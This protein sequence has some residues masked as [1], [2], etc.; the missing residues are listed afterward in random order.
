MAAQR[1]R[2][3]TTVWLVSNSH[4]Q[5]AAGGAREASRQPDV[6]GSKLGVACVGVGPAPGEDVPVGLVVVGPA[7]S[8]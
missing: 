4:L 3:Q 6:V 1:V 8:K 2:S 7:S 5:H